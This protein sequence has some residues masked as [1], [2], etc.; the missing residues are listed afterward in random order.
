MGSLSENLRKSKQHLMDL[1]P[2]YG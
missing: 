1:M 2:D